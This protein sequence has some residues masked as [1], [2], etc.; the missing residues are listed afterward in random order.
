MYMK[1]KHI[2]KITRAGK[3]SLYLNIPAELVDELKL[4]ERQKMTIEKKGASLVIKDWK[5]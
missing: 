4:R 5:K 2:R 3:R 1:K